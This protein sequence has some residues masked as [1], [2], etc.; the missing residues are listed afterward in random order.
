MAK[1]PR[2][3][4]AGTTSGEEKVEAA[5]QTLRLTIRGETREVRP[6]LIDFRT[7]TLVRKATGLPLSDWMTSFDL[8]TIRVLWWLGGR[9]SQ[10]FLT[11]EKSN[12]TFPD[13]LGADDIDFEQVTPDDEDGDSDPS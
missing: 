2:P 1:A 3:G 6:G 10:P 7:R 12:E 8:D 9:E 4:S 11:F 5:K 13:D